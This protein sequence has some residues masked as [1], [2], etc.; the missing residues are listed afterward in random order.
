M[1]RTSYELTSPFLTCASQPPSFFFIFSP[2]G[3]KTGR[4]WGRGRWR[5]NRDLNRDLNELKSNDLAVRYIIRY[6]WW[7]K[8]WKVRLWARCTGSSQGRSTI[9]TKPSSPNSEKVKSSARSSRS[10]T[11]SIRLPRAISRESTRKRTISPMRISLLPKPLLRLIWPA[12]KLELPLN[13]PQ[14]NPSRPPSR[15]PDSTPTWRL[16]QEM[17]QISTEDPNRRTTADS[18][19][20]PLLPFWSRARASSRHLEV[21]T[22][23]SSSTTTPNS[24]RNTR[25][26]PRTRSQLWSNFSGKRRKETTKLWGEETEDWEPAN[27]SPAEDSSGKW[28]TSVVWMQLFTGRE[29]Q[30]KP[31]TPG[32]TNL[33]GL[34]STTERWEPEDLWPSE[35]K[36]TP[37]Q[38]S[39][40]N[41]SSSIRPNITPNIIIANN[42][43]FLF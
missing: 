21:N 33:E 34:W 7:E 14:G 26:G 30:S 40:A 3:Q 23:P 11:P 24:R 42:N 29:C 20:L 32:T 31:E 27:P 16:P 35:D 22:S 12:R 4:R 8:S 41:D 5:Q 2:E 9:S 38:C 25:D 17:A 10:G 15:A 43:I 36:L 6:L 39:W 37:W 13:R 28:D 19:I 18:E 1:A